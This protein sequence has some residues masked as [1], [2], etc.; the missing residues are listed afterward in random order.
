[1]IISKNNVGEKTRHLLTVNGVA[2][3]S[4]SGETHRW[5]AD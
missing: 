2:D 5:T 3:A 1:M 4:H